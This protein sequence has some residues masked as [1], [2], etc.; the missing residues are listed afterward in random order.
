M[1][2][3]QQR[4]AEASGLTAAENFLATVSVC[5]EDWSVGHLHLVIYFW[6]FSL[7]TRAVILQLHTIALLLQIQMKNLYI[8]RYH[9]KGQIIIYECISHTAFNVRVLE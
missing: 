3:K 4:S 5:V 6:L 7:C 2:E 8:I 1:Q 9:I